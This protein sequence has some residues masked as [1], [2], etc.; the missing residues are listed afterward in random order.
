MTH[1]QTLD[2]IGRYQAPCAQTGLARRDRLAVLSANR[3]EA[4]R[5]AMPAPGV[6]PGR[7]LAAPAGL[8]RRSAQPDRQRPSRRALARMHANRAMP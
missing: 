4:W 5:A 8:G 2:L 3:A 1:N 6:G 7:D